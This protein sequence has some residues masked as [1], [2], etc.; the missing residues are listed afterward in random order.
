MLLLDGRSRRWAVL[1]S[2]NTKSGAAIV[3]PKQ[4]ALMEH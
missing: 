3:M 4:E 2:A 1:Y